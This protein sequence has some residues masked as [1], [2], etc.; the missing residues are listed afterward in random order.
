MQFASHQREVSELQKKGF[1]AFCDVEKNCSS[2]FGKWSIECKRI[3]EWNKYS[4]QAEQ[5]SVKCIH[6]IF[7][8]NLKIN[9]M[10][11]FSIQNLILDH[12]IPSTATLNT[13]IN[14]IGKQKNINK[15]SEI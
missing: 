12:Y 15:L 14:N 5:K 7:Y 8:R 1:C 6:N 2:S 9:N 10:E 4:N 11:T 3:C 13:G